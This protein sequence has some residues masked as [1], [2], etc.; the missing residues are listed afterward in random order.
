MISYMSHTKL[1]LRRYNTPFG[2]PI[3]STEDSQ[4]KVAV[5]V[6]PITRYKSI[7]Y[8]HAVVNRSR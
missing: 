6:D 5:K 2:I 4:Q 1:L 3:T 7:N 8:Y